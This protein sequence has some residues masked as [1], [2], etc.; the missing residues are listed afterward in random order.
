M[1]GQAARRRRRRRIGLAVGL[2]ALIVVAGL[3]LVRPRAGGESV[4][5]AP[6]A[7]APLDLV[8]EAG[9]D[10]GEGMID[11]APPR[12]RAPRSGASPAAA[13]PAIDLPP[14]GTPASEAIRQ[15]QPLVEQGRA[16]AAHALAMQLVGCQRAR[17]L[18]S[19]EV[20]RE[21][22][23]RRYR[24]RSG[25]DPLSDAE[26]DVV[27]R[28][29]ERLSAERDRCAGIDGEL[30][31]SRVELLEQ[32]A[33]AGSTD[34]MLDYVDW[35]LQDIGGYD[36]VLRNFDEVARRRAVAAGFLHRALALGDC[37][38]LD[39]MAEAY[40]GARGRRSWVFTADPWL[41]AVYGEA[42]A[43]APGAAPVSSIAVDAL[44]VARQ[45]AARAQAQALVQRHCRG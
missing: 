44:D 10:A 22:L 33:K 2:L 16:D 21:R 8:D 26:L 28:N 45:A 23:L 13:V 24:G 27:A 39:V 38:A 11:A 35:G 36:G 14:P 32:A 6:P 18:G 37:R 31:A 4:A 9:V 40:A 25:Q 30:F 19:D 43:L 20:L 34:A 15:L 1:E 17:N 5:V 3:L 12:P 42:A 7:P 29:L 41:A